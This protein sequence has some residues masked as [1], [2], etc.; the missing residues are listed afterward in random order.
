MRSTFNV[1]PAEIERNV[2]GLSRAV[3]ALAALAVRG[4]GR[5]RKEKDKGDSRPQNHQGN[6][7]TDH[8]W[9][10]IVEIIIPGLPHFPR[11]HA[12]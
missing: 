10:G 1:V 12:L 5:R 6:P 11:L 2:W 4:M 9:G 3:S 7:V 8:D